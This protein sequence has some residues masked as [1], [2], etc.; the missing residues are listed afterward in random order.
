MGDHIC[1]DPDRHDQGAELISCC[2]LT[3]ACC[4]LIGQSATKPVQTGRVEN[5]SRSQAVARV[6]APRA[7]AVFARAFSMTKS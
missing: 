2:C 6:I 7:V 4:V 3:S 5:P 1:S